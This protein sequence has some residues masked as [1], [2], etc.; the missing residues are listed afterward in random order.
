[1][2]IQKNDNLEKCKFKKCRFGKMQTWKNRYW[3]IYRLVKKNIGKFNNRKSDIWEKEN[4]ENW[5]LGK[6]K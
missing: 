1:M 5:K 4:K 3:E 2:Y 6:R